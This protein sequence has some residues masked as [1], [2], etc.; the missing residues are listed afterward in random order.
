MG[1]EDRFPAGIPLTD[2]GFGSLIWRSPW[3]GRSQLRSPF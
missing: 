1:M 2:G 3:T